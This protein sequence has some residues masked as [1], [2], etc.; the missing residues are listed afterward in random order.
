MNSNFWP[1]MLKILPLIA[2]A[3]RDF[4]A[5]PVLNMLVATLCLVVIIV[6]IMIC[7]ICWKLINRKNP[8]S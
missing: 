2:P 4:L 3:L 7:A 6:I 5:L 8:F 1:L